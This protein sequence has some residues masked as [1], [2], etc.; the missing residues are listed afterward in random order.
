MEIADIVESCAPGAEV[1]I[2][3]RKE[4]VNST[5]WDFYV[6]VSSE[7]KNDEYP[8]ARGVERIEIGAGAGESKNY[9]RLLKIGDFL[10]PGKEKHHFATML[11][12]DEQFVLLMEYLGIN[13]IEQRPRSG[14]LF[15]MYNQVSELAAKLAEKGCKVKFAGEPAKAEKLAGLYDALQQSD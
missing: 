5:R 8:L 6:A 13:E 7:E 12:F 2:S 10:F 14:Q 15:G 11:E 9:R 1:S 4:D 3:V